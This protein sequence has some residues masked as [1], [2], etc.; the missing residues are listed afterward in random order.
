MIS[1]KFMCGQIL[2]PGV[3]PSKFQFYFSSNGK[4]INNVFRVFSQQ[5]TKELHKAIIIWSV[6]H[7]LGFSPLYMQS[8]FFPLQTI[9]IIMTISE[10]GERRRGNEIQTNII[11]HLLLTTGNWLFKLISMSDTH[12]SSLDA[13]LSTECKRS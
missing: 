4:S 13:M 1:F 3:L 9:R 7:P 11:D 8:P 6:C 5:K 2:Y 12:L 10:P